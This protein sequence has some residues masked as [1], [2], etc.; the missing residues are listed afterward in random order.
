MALRRGAWVRRGFRA[1]P[2]APTPAARRDRLEVRPAPGEWAPGPEGA[3]ITSLVTISPLRPDVAIDDART[4]LERLPVGQH[5]P[6]DVSVRTHYAR[7]QVLSEMMTDERRPLAAPVL[8]LA[9][10]VD[11]DGRS[12]L[13][14][15]LTGSSEP[16]ARV[17]GLCDGAPEDASAPDFVGDAVAYLLSHQ[18]PVG[19]QY[20]NSPGR[21]A[22]DIR[23]AVERHRRLAG[24]AL[25]HQ[26]DP[27][28]ELRADFL[29]E[30]ELP[31]R[32]GT[33]AR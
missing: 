16:L 26:G 14:E 1:Q 19:L 6:F 13:Q 7:I 3:F 9:A 17:L 11:G 21:T 18:V 23:L 4:E 20:V 12:W 28:A 29:R 10:D 15:V 30:F 33:A 27:P 25:G 8:I 5:S 32:P 31:S 22:S 2:P 24:F